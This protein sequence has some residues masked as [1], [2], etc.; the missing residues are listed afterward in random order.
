MIWRQKMSNIL[1]GLDNNQ[2]LPHIKMLHM[3]H[4]ENAG[5]V[6]AATHGKFS[7]PILTRCTQAP[8]E[9]RSCPVEAVLTGS[10]AALP[11]LI[12]III[13]SP[14]GMRHY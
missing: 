14:L 9:R 2:A 3:S 8:T 12:E 7:V 6:A 4:T 1:S 5:H 11:S 13:S 10:Q